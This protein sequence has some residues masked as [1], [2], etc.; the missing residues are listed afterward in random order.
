MKLSKRLEAIVE[1]AP[2][3]AL[4]EGWAKEAG[5]AGDAEVAEELG[6][7]GAMAAPPR[8]DTPGSMCVA[9]VGTDHGYVPIRLLQLKKAERAIAMDVRK[10]P[11]ERARE[12]IAQ[13]GLEERIETR[14]SDG[15]AGL[16]PGEADTVVIAGMGGE[17]MLRILREGGHVRDGIR[18]WILS[19]QSELKLFRH[20]LEDLGLS[21]VREAMVEEDGKYYTVMAVEPGAMHYG[22]EFRYR[23]GDCLIRQDSPVLREFLGREAALCREILRQLERQDTPGARA[24]LSE[25]QGK[26][27]EI[28]EAYHAMQGNHDTP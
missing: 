10:G 21:I 14:L 19:P 13:F 7:P 23:Y 5:R 17:L 26:L 18:H 12:H 16:R 22:D 9:D 27:L 2:G 11:L 15:L 3:C 1:M 4:G 6:R 8:L 24:R 20:G 25:I 28:E